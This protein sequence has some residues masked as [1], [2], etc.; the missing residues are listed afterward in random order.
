MLRCKG[1]TLTRRKFIDLTD[2]EIFAASTAVLGFDCATLERQTLHTVFVQRTLSSTA[3]EK[4]Y[5][6][7]GCLFIGTLILF[8]IQILESNARK[9]NFETPNNGQFTLSTQL[10]ITNEVR[11]GRYK[12][13]N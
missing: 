2:L 3:L 5:E 10:I 4:R 13:I 6:D 8:L 9:V 12:L 11:K 7:G 1:L